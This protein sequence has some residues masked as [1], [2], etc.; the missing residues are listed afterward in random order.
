M[1]NHCKLSYRHDGEK[2]SFKMEMSKDKFKKY[3]ELTDKVLNLIDIQ[4]ED[5]MSRGD[6][7]GCVEAIMMQA[8]NYTEPEIREGDPGQRS[9]GQRQ[10][11]G[12]A[13]HS[14]LY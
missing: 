12:R 3:M 9:A 14:A 5:K 7:Q 6:L 2:E 11:R 8:I 10:G 1:I 13:L 4:A